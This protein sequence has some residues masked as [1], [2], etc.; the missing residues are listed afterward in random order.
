MNEINNV[1]NPTIISA[2]DN[3]DDVVISNNI[4]S[5]ET[6]F[7]TINNELEDR[8][9]VTLNTTLTSIELNPDEFIKRLKQKTLPNC[10][11]T[12]N[13]DAII[14]DC[15]IFWLP[16]RLV[17]TSKVIIRRCHNITK[18]IGLIEAESILISDCINFTEIVKKPEKNISLQ[19]SHCNNFVKLP[20]DFR[21]SQLYINHCDKL[22]KLPEDIMIYTLLSIW[23]CPQIINLPQQFQQ[24]KKTPQDY[25]FV[26]VMT[27]TSCDNIIIPK[28]LKVIGTLTLKNCNNIISIPKIHTGSLIIDSCINLQHLPECFTASGNVTIKNCRKLTSFPESWVNRGH[29]IGACHRIKCIN[30][31]ITEE[32]AESFFRQYPLHNIHCTVESS[33]NITSLEELTKFWQKKAENKDNINLENLTTTETLDLLKFSYLLTKTDYYLNEFTKKDLA[34]RVITILRS[35]SKNNWFKEESLKIIRN[36]IVCSYSYIQSQDRVLISLGNLEF[37]P[38]LYNLITDAK[39]YQKV[40]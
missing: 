2:T 34:G 19:I 18:I 4:G 13:G 21:I 20:D 11:I 40:P 17:V 8:E 36:A 26:S 31:G 1:I 33:Y 30:T 5:V 7:D 22:T 29:F 25:P 3:G 35:I 6:T 28:E 37:L 39:L 14:E 38:R 16:S 24:P 15:D 23:H 32:Y 10:T 27:I 12:V 9:I